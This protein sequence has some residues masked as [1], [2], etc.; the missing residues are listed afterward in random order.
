MKAFLTKGWVKT[1]GKMGLYGLYFIG[2]FWLTSLYLEEKTLIK[3]LSW[4]IN[5]YAFEPIMLI[6]HFIVLSLLTKKI[7]PS[8]V[9]VSALYIVFMLIN[10]EMVKVFGLIFSPIDIKHSLQLIF[11]KEALFS[12]WKELMAFVLMVVAIVVIFIKAPANRFIAKNHFKCVL[13]V[14]LCILLIGFNK[15]EIAFGIKKNFKMSG[16][17]VPKTFAEYHGFLFSLY[18]RAM[19]VRGVDAPTGYSKQ[20]ID[21]IT[22]RYDKKTVNTVQG[23][24][25]VI[26]FFI[27]AFADPYEVGIETSK[28]PIPNFRSYAERSISGLVTSPEMGGRSA[29]PE[30]ELLTGLS[31]RYVPEKSIPYIDY[32]NQ[33][34]PSIAR[35]FKANGYETNAVHV[36]SLSF[37]NYQKAY[38]LLGF[39]NV[40]TLHDKPGIEYDPAGRFPSEKSLV[41]R[42][43]EITDSRS[44]PQFIFSFPNSTHGFWGYKAY[45]NAEIDVYGDFIEDGEQHLKT[46]VNAIHEADKAIK[47][48]ILHYE[49][50]NKPAVIMVLGD[51][52]PSLPEFRQKLADDFHAKKGQK[53]AYK[54]RKNMKRSFVIKALN[55]DME[56]KKKSHQ[57]PYF[58]WS[59]NGGDENKL[60]INTSMN[61]LSSQ[62]LKESKIKTSPLYNLINEI[63]LA[64]KVVDKFEGDKV[65]GSG[66]LGDYEMIQ[67]DVMYGKRYYKVKDTRTHE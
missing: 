64:Y 7:F 47:R 51:H 34:Y 27:E 57:V 44:E 30:F 5:A 10:A 41:D 65:E 52:Q 26:I 3:P 25:D 11:A 45:L 9:L 35:E 62:L 56:L 50:S 59:S 66:L 33:P 22:E 31:M 20:V 39:D 49:K 18:F 61:L 21:E 17:A 54:S 6:L 53:I 8:A 14:L 28:D 60:K 1:A 58:I 2:L 37:F 4:P 12:Y 42:I 32:V 55:N 38:P 40:E 36:A 29:N 24:P 15:H 46:Y 67:Y 23:K 43:T 63:F 13:G 16:Q 48:L 19:K